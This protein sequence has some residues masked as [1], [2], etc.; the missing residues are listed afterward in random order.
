DTKSIC[1]FLWRQPFVVIRRG[2]L[3][4]LSQQFAEGRALL[5]RRHEGQRDVR[6]R[7]GILY[8]PLVLS[9]RSKDTT[10]SGQRHK[11]SAIDRIRQAVR[12]GQLLAKRKTG[13]QQRRNH[14]RR[15]PDQRHVLSQN[16]VAI[17]AS[18]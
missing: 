18:Y 2:G 8:Y 14:T 13:K 1:I 5:R 4:L 16:T 15:P 17:R 7:K 10:F 9:V 12:H 11:S 6:Q 3:L